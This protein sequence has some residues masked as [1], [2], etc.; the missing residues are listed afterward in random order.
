MGGGGREGGR[1]GGKE[2]GKEDRGIEGGGGLSLVWG[3]G[4]GVW[5]REDRKGRV[6]VDAAS[7]GVCGRVW[8]CGLREREEERMLE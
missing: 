7:E 3:E 1:E 2:G 6:R 8:V 4:G 5:E